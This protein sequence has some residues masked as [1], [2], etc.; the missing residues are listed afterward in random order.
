MHS[1]RVFRIK[2]IGRLFYKVQKIAHIV[3]TLVLVSCKQ[4]GFCAGHL[5]L[6]VD[7]SNI[8]IACLYTASV[9]TP[10]HKRW[11]GHTQL[12]KTLSPNNLWPQCSR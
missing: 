11:F 12:S 3:K 10:R 5:P 6:T 2:L 4:I 8:N 9:L 1:S 7:T